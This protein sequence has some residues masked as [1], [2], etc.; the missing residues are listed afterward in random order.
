MVKVIEIF[1]FKF[2]KFSF[3]KAIFNFGEGVFYL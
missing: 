2:A 3:G 1:N